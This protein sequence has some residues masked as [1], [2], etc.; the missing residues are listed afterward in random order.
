MYWV[1]IILNNNVDSKEWLRLPT[2]TTLG[3]LINWG[4]IIPPIVRLHCVATKTPATR[5]IVDSRASQHITT[6]KHLYHMYKLILGCKV[7]METCVKGCAWS[8]RMHDVIH[9]PDLHSNLF[10]A[11]ILIL[12]GFKV[13]STREGEQKWDIG[14]GFIG[15][16]FV[17]I[18][19]HDEW[20]QNEFV[21]AFRCKLAFF[22][23]LALKV[24]A[25]QRQQHEN[26]RFLRS[27]H[28]KKLNP[29]HTNWTNCPTP[30]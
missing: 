24:G 19:Q 22:E 25:C 17:P 28:K 2:S 12:R 14:R 21:G 20:G 1:H 30:W 13:H 7:F 18:R 9:M 15:V 29:H 26:M 10:L 3:S 6:Y 8:I 23:I 11:S 16:Q 4:G 5:W 27:Q